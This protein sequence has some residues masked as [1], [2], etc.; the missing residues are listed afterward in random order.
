[1]SSIL[2]PQTFWPSTTV[3][4]TLIGTTEPVNINEGMD[5]SVQM[6]IHHFQ[7]SMWYVEARKNQAALQSITNTLPSEV[8]LQRGINSYCQ[9]W[10][11]RDGR[12]PQNGKNY[13][14]WTHIEFPLPHPGCPPL[15]PFAWTCPS[16]PRAWLIGNLLYLLSNSYWV[17]LDFL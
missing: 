7:K 17:S 1:M 11:L 15:H 8:F 2:I 9:L 13:S 12:Q 5:F 6:L 10:H 4:W 3:R 14:I 16:A